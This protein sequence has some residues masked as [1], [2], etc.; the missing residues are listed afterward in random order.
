MHMMGGLTGEC[1]IDHFLLFSPQPVENTRTYRRQHLHST[2]FTCLKCKVKMYRVVICHCSDLFIIIGSGQ[3]R[4]SLWVQ[5][6]TL[7]IKL[8]TIILT[9][10]SAKGIDGDNESS[11]ISL[12]LRNALKEKENISTN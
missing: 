4:Q 1:V 12:K 6:A 2:T 7:G 5:L 11:T 10:F 8:V 3:P 9:K